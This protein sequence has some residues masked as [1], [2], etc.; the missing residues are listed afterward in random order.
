MYILPEHRNSRLMIT[1]TAA[2]LCYAKTHLSERDEIGVINV[3][4]NK[5]LDRPGLQRIFNRLG[6]QHKEWRD[7]KEVILFEFDQVSYS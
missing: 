7:N 4:E 3:N 1:G 2:M 6:Y 5:K